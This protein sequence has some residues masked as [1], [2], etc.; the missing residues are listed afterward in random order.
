MLLTFC[1]KLLKIC[2]PK[3]LQDDISGD[4][5]EE[6]KQLRLESISTNNAEFWL[7]R[8]TILTC[9]RYMF[10]VKNIFISFVIFLSLSL[11]SLMAIGIVWLS[12]AYDVSSFPNNFWQEFN[13]TSHIVFFEPAFW[14]YAPTALTEGMDLNLWV[15][16]PAVTYSIIALTLLNI[17][18]HKKQ[19]SAILYAQISLCLML[20]PYLWGSAQFLIYDIPMFETGPI[21]ATMWLSILYMAL[22]IGY[23]LVQKI[24]LIYSQQ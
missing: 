3:I 13:S 7:V 11:F 4:I 9:S 20:I 22:P 5:E 18:D 15:D 12:T 24:N 1:K 16:G 21:I 2:L 10:S 19:F 17:L 6:Y 14:G 8:Q 23:T